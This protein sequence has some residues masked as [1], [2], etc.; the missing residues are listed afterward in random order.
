[1]SIIAM[2]YPS[3]IWQ[4]DLCSFNSDS[5]HVRQL[6]VPFSRLTMA[7]IRYD[8]DVCKI[9]I[10]YT[11]RWCDSKSF[12]PFAAPPLIQNG[13]I[14]Q[15]AMSFKFQ[16]YALRPVWKERTT[17]LPLDWHL[18]IVERPWLVEKRSIVS[19]ESIN[20]QQGTSKQTICC[21][22]NETKLVPV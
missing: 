8:D 17:T 1:M 20:C 3:G 9:T 2:M 4:A 22:S 12:L 19:F 6:S 5:G 16:S 10:Q 18:T 7:M 13:Y 11:T 15:R 21:F 14:K